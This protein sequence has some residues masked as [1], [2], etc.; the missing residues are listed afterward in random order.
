MQ[1][2][3]GVAVGVQPNLLQPEPHLLDDDP[4]RICLRDP[5]VGARH[6]HD[7]QIRDAATEGQAASFQVG[8]RPVGQAAPELIQQ[9][10]LSDARLTDDPYHLA[11]PGFH[12]G[13]RPAQ[14]CQGMVTADEL[15]QLRP[16][17]QLRS[18]RHLVQHVAQG[19]H[20]RFAAYKPAQRASSQPFNRGSPRPRTGDPKRMNR[21]AGAW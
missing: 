7:R 10:R 16:G 19:P 17:A 5:A 20:L 2:V 1:H 6:I 18:D 15:S 14:R 9:A 3:G 4:G 21:A 11:M 12:L 8:D 13:Q